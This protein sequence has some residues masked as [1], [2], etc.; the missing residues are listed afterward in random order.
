[1]NKFQ[2]TLSCTRET[3]HNT[4]NRL[5][6]DCK[7]VCSGVSGQQLLVP[8]TSEVTLAILTG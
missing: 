1:M 4:K 8:G 3:A 5:F 6:P 2:T 7:G